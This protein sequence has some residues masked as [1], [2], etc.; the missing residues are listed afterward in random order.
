MG[1]LKKK[2]G[3]IPIFLPQFGA[4]MFWFSLLINEYI[5]SEILLQNRNKHLSIYKI[6]QVNEF[7]HILLSLIIK[8]FF[9]KCLKKE[10]T[11][12]LIVKITVKTNI[13][14]S[15]KIALYNCIAIPKHYKHEQ[16]IQIW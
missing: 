4:P 16:N 12:F 3:Q 5:V 8:D 11:Q 2:T 9:I 14:N 6:I 1:V 10:N 13:K 15:T 7:S